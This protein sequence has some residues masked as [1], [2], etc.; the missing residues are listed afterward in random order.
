MVPKGPGDNSAVIFGI[1]YW[2]EP[3]CYNENS[4][5]VYTRVTRVISWIR[6]YMK[7]SKN[8]K[9]IKCSKNGIK[10]RKLRKKGLRA[11]IPH[12]KTFKARQAKNRSLKTSRKYSKSKE[13]NLKR[14][15][16]KHLPKCAKIPRWMRNTGKTGTMLGGRIMGGKSASS[17]IPW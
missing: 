15:N 1:V 3:G 12:V 14:S 7:K 17:A 9:S 4:P 13:L 11:R 6:R 2:G 5:G 8:H 10:C 16:S